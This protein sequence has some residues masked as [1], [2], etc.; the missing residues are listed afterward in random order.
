MEYFDFN[1]FSDIQKIGSGLFGE[2]IRANWRN[3]KYFALKSFK[4]NNEVVKEI[5]HEVMLYM[6]EPTLIIYIINFTY[7]QLYFYLA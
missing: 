2:V 6:N 1:H 3:S 7:L 4:F 5:V